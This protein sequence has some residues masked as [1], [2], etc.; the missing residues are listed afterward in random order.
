MFQKILLVAVVMLENDTF[1]GFPALKTSGKFQGRIKGIK[2]QPLTLAWRCPS[3]LPCIRTVI[4]QNE[5]NY[6]SFS[7][8]SL[9]SSLS[10]FLQLLIYLET[11]LEKECMII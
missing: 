1:W 6:N 8:H 9:I 11:R 3:T 10:E 5:I 7:G 4:S 2:R